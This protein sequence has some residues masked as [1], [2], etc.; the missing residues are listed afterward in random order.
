MFRGEVFFATSIASRQTRPGFTGCLENKEAKSA[1]GFYGH[2][3][4][5]SQ[6]VKRGDRRSGSYEMRLNFEVLRCVDNCQYCN[7][8]GSPRLD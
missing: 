6:Y 5:C 7:A 3:T 1:K 4:I 8:G 2:H